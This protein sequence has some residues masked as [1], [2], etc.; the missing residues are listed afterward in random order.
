MD[1]GEAALG[2]QPGRAVGG[3]ARGGVAVVLDDQ[4]QSGGVLVVVAVGDQT[5]DVEEPPVQYARGDVGQCLGRVDVQVLADRLRLHAA[6]EVRR[7]LDGGDAAPVGEGPDG[8]LVT[9]D[10]GDDMGVR[11]GGR[12]ARGGHRDGGRSSGEGARRGDRHGYQG[13]AEGYQPSA[14]WG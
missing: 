11:G 14:A 5:G 9:G 2:G 8:D 12:L 3:P 10:Q 1:R 4:R 7:P 13:R 6:G